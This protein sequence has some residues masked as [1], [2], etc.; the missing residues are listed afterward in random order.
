MRSVS[1]RHLHLLHINPTTLT[2]LCS[3]RP[4]AQIILR[5][6]SFLRPGSKT[7]PKRGRWGFERVSVDVVKLSSTC[8]AL[9]RIFRSV[10]DEHRT[11][12]PVRR[13]G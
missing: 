3:A 9:Y 4:H 1:R 7:H 12:L 5:I 10:R 8:S 11:Q 6:V 2:G 13:Q